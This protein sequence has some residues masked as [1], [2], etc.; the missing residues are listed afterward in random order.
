[1][2]GT[3]DLPDGATAAQVQAKA[4]EIQITPFEGY[5]FVGWTPEFA[6]INGKDQEYTATYKIG[7]FY[8]PVGEG[9]VKID[10]KWINTVVKSTVTVDDTLMPGSADYK[11]V[12]ADLTAKAPNGIP[13]W[14]NYVLGLTGAEGEKLTIWGAAPE[15]V[16][17]TGAPTGNYVIFGELTAP[18]GWK[19]EDVKVGTANAKSGYEVKANY[20]LAVRNAND[21]TYSIVADATPVPVTTLEPEVKVPMDSVANQTL[22]FV[23]QITVDRVN[24]AP[25]TGDGE[26]NNTGTGN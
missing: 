9:G 15:T 13:W 14:Q 11:K 20:K 5:T 25:T 22:A 2:L 8:Y 10:P 12:I 1:M 23:I 18:D 19:L 24:T 6:A 26:G 3:K 17:K 16:E 7:A 21:G 4:N